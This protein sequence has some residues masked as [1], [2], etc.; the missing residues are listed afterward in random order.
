VLV[1]LMRALR[2][3]DRVEIDNAI[4]TAVAKT[5]PEVDETAA[6]IQASALAELSAEERE[7]IVALRTQWAPSVDARAPAGAMIISSFLTAWS[8]YLKKERG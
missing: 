8:P 4:N 2:P 6:R 3:A 5:Q 1:L 7:R